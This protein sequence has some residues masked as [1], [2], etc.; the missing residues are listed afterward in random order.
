MTKETKEPFKIGIRQLK[1]GNNNIRYWI[2]YAPV[3]ATLEDILDPYAW[4]IH[5]SFMDVHDIIHV[6]WEDNSKECEL[7]VL[8]KNDKMAKVAVRGK[9][10][11]YSEEDVAPIPDQ[12]PLFV[13]YHNPHYKWVVMRKDNNQILEKEFGTE[14]Q[15]KERLQVL[16]KQYGS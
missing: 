4:S 11:I 6:I 5:S 7:R 14:A 13:K 12:C 8:D 2:Y 15:A 16:I 10:T 9:V 1:S 3:D